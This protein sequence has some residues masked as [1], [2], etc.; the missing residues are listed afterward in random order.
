LLNLSTMTENIK[1][2]LV[3]DASYILAFLLN[4]NNSPVDE[5][6]EDYKNGNI[7]LSSN[8]LLPFEVG[9]A[10]K[11]AVIR[12]R[13]DKKQAQELYRLFL[14]LDIAIEPIDG[15]ETLAIALSKK[16]SFYDAAYVYSAKH[17][18]RPLLTLDRS[19]KKA[20]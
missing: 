10:L 5:L 18:G 12:K 20:V 2:T 3:I 9:N 7:H 17:A 11:T 1:T 8:G 4:E 13:L 14:D 16:L 15:N 6:I 19:L